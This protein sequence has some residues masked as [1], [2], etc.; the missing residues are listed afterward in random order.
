QLAANLTTDVI[1]AAASVPD[2]HINDKNDLLARLRGLGRRSAAGQ[3]IAVCRHQNQPG[4]GRGWRTFDDVLPAVSRSPATS[5]GLPDYRNL[6]AACSGSGFA[7][8]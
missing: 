4:T 7:R 8:G 6:S 1:V 3:G 2:I 5:Q